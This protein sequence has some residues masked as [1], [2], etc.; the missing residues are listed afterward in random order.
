MTEEEVSRT[1]FRSNYV[2]FL[3]IGISVL[4]F[5]MIWSFLEA[6]L[7]A[8]IA[9]GL[10]QPVYRWFLKRLKGREAFASVTTML[11]LFVVIVGPVAVFLG[12]VV[13][14]AIEVSNT[15]IP[16]AK[17]HFGNAENMH[18]TER[19][20]IDRFPAL[21]E[22]MPSQSDL[23]QG[24]GGVAQKAGTFLVASLTKMTSGTAAFFLNFFVML[25]A[26]FFFLISGRKILDKILSYSPLT[27]EEDEQLVGRFVSVAR[28]TLKGS[29]IIGI[30]QGALGGIG[31]AFAGI[32]GAAFWGTLMAILSVLPGLGT[33]IVWGPA[34]IYLM[35]QGEVTSALLLLAWC[36]GVVGTIDNVMRPRL[37]GKDAKMPDLLI[38]LSTLGGLFLFGAVGFVIGPIICSLFMAVWEIY[39]RTFRHVLPR[40]RVAAAVD[41]EGQVGG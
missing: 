16:W 35:V 22:M 8:G 28:A 12:I 26:M 18:A 10:L 13:D 14:Q 21:E 4:F 23:L 31:L 20:I 9:A 25:Y 24:M 32:N 6:L 3:T 29:V 15:A 34:V 7:L 39:G 2:L 30:V 38:L 17:E 41:G 19:W 11:L 1:R 40:E 33:A 36:A 27:S 5:A 37:V